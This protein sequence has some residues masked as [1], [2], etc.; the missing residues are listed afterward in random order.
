[1]KLILFRED[2]TKEEKLIKILV[3]QY[4][5]GSPAFGPSVW[6]RIGRHRLS[7][8]IKLEFWKWAIRAAFPWIR[9]YASDATF[10]LLNFSHFLP[11]NAWQDIISLFITFCLKQYHVTIKMTGKG[12]KLLANTFLVSQTWWNGIISLGSI[13]LMNA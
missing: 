2:I 4:H 3:C 9:A 12:L 8:F 1:M 5:T 6:N 11:L 7:S 10:S 13:M